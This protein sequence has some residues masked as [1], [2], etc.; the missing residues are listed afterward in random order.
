MS[1]VIQ[2][3]WVVMPVYNEEACIEYVVQEWLLAL[4]KQ[5][6]R[7][8]L[9]LL[10]DG[11]KDRTLSLLQAMAAKESELH[12]VDKPNSGHG[13]TCIQGYRIALEN[14]ADWVLQIDSDGQCDPIFIEKFFQKT[15]QAPVIYGYRKSRD[16]GKRRFLISRFV[17]LFAL[18]ATKTWVKDANV[19]YR[20]MRADTL[21]KPL[22]HIPADF[23]LANVLLSVLQKRSWNILWIPIHFRDRMGGTSAVKNF[24]FVKRGT[25]LFRQ[26]QKTVTHTS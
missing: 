17:S 21:K 8:T 23:H 18:V 16:D 15:S 14:K 10:N 11:S 20:L 24:S 22:E 3:L 4:R 9:C 1:N 19:P 13:Q 7:F 6:V 5:G 26:L 25:Q 2:N 12:V